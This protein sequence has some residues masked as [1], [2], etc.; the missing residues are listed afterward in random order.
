MA[1][2]IDGIAASE[3]IDSSGEVVSIA[4]MDISSLDKTGVLNWEHK[5]DL[6]AQIVGKILKA[7]KI[8][9][10]DDCD[11]D[12]QSYYWNKIQTPFVYILGEL[13]DDYTDS[14]K[15]VAG[16]FRY[17]AD[18]PEQ[19]DVLGFSIEGA[20]IAKE[21]MVVTRSIARKCTL[22]QAPCNKAVISEIVPAE[23]PN[24]DDEIHSIFKTESGIG[25]LLIKA[26]NNDELYALLNKKEDPARHASALGIEPMN[27]K[28]MN[29][30]KPNL[31]KADTANK[32]L[33]GQAASPPKSNEPAL[34][35]MT[36]NPGEK[37][38]QTTSGK[39][40]FSHAKV[41]EYQNFSSADHREAAQMHAKRAEGSV[42]N[43]KLGDHHTEKM[44]LHNAAALTAEKREHRFG[45]AL[46][47]KK[48]AIK[49]EAR[50]QGLHKADTLGSGMAAPSQLSGTSALTKESLDKKG[51]KTDWLK[52]ADQEYSTWDKKEEFK[53]FMK[54]K[55][56]HL[57]EC[58]IDAIGKTLALKKS[59]EA[60]KNLK[61]LIKTDE[62][63]ISE[64]HPDEL[65]TGKMYDI[66]LKSGHYA[67][68]HCS[69]PAA[70]RFSSENETKHHKVPRVKQTPNPKL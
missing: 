58:E 52:R 4:G 30:S 39:S 35:S 3:N 47:A 61:K 54:K 63:P 25:V 44:K 50:R 29:A 7:K 46:A 19:N 13:M 17:D 56:P 14:A 5:A 11:N 33:N 66:G 69:T 64:M 9:S 55:M 70:H 53:S 49:L 21:G 68:Y 59:V 18:R 20:K 22:T 23:A 31:A 38:G 1:T 6:P 36:T 27:K 60:E 16:M 41:G 67:K 32:T 57:H 12:R 24:D 28:E 42:G 34:P 2:F 40:V 65:V 15:E 45:D 43:P 26:E 10:Q 37:I 48:K 51:Q 8:F 62:K